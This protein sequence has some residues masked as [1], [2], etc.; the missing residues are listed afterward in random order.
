VPI[1]QMSFNDL[2]NRTLV[3]DFIRFVGA[4]FLHTLCS[5]VIGYSLA[6]SFC[7]AKRKY[8]SF[9]AGIFIAVLLHGLYDFSIINLNGYTKFGIPVVI[10]LTLAFI[11]FSGF[12]KLKK[13][14]SICKLN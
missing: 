2:I 8:V 10:I 14:K 5:A 6:I 13:L 12:K 4:T 3:I 7:Q 1:G 11:V 9:A